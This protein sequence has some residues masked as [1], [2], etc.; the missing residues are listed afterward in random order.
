MR[1]WGFGA[2]NAVFSNAGQVFWGAFGL[3]SSQPDAIDYLVG[4]SLQVSLLPQSLTDQKYPTVIK[5][6]EMLWVSK[7]KTEG[8]KFQ[9]KAI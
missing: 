3:S 6:I 1:V 5:E 8:K 4:D 9:N 2:N 7:K